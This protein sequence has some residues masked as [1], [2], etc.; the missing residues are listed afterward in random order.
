MQIHGKQENSL[1][2][3]EYQ[4]IKI[5]IRYV[6]NEMQKFRNIA[7]KFNYERPKKK[8]HPNHPKVIF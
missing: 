6:Q 5:E 2:N 3:I 4:K 1:C 7:A 8:D